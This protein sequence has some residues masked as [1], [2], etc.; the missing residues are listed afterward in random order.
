MMGKLHDPQCYDLAEYFLPAAAT[1]KQKSELAQ[2][3]QDA[4]EDW[5]SAATEQA[6]QE[7]GT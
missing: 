1:K 7:R 6:E 5:L 2:H 4:V 3:I